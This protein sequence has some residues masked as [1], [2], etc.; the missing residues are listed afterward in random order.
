LKATARTRKNID[1]S[2]LYPKLHFTE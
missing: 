2:I 1:G